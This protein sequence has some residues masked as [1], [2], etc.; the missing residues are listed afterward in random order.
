MLPETNKVVYDIIISGAGPAGSTC[1]IGLRNSGLKVAL[2][3]RAVF[4]RDK[5]C[6]DAIPGRAVKVLRQLGPEYEASFRKFAPKLLTK[7]TRLFYNKR[8]LAF[9]WKGE[10]YTCARM[11]FDHFLFEK[12]AAT[13]IDVFT[14]EQVTQ[15]NRHDGVFSLQ[16]KTGNALHCKLLI[17]A[18]G[19]NGVTARQLAARVT[20]KTNHVGSVRAYYNN[21]TTLRPDTT[22]VYFLKNFL[23]SY[24]WVFPLPGN[25]ANVGFGMLSA[26]ISRRRLDLKK[27]FYEFIDESPQLKARLNGAIQDGPLEGFGLPLGGRKVAI[28]GDGF[29]LTGD[30]ASIIDPMS[31]DGI[32]NAMVSGL[33]AATQAISCFDRSDLSDGFML[34]YDNALDQ[35]LGGELRLHLRSR[36]VLAAFP[37]LLD[38]VF[39]AG[40]NATLRRIIQKAL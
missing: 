38:V 5:V 15:I 16:T 24:M 23:P 14:G 39:A 11:D 27:L 7:T 26:E 20:D 28:S 32:G 37:G 2:I 34:G 4:P 31:G 18:D 8:E 33:L 36:K 6:G 12:A 25:R 29:M 13:G 30:A 17:G 21:V 19:A 35:R 1:A 10:A 22:E 40:S 3:D 9:D